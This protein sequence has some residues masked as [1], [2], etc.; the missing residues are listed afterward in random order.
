MKIIIFNGEKCNTYILFVH[1]I[2]SYE[3][4]SNLSM[5]KNN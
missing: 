5:V 2:G 1:E 4:L 3:I